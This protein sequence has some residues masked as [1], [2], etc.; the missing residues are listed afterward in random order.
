MNPGI[1]YSLA[2][3]ALFASGVPLSKFLLKTADPVLFAGLCYFASG[4]GLFL[5][6]RLRRSSGEAPLARQDWPWMLGSIL[7]G[8]I[9]APILLMKGIA[10]SPQ[11]SRAAILFTSEIIFTTL[12]AGALFKEYISGRVWFAALL[13]AGGAAALSGDSAMPHGFDR[14]LV[15]IVVACFIWGFD[16]NFTTKLSGKDPATI[17]M[18]KGLVAGTFNVLLALHGGA[19]LPSPQVFAG[20]MVTGF[21]AYGLSLIVFVKGMRALGA[22][23]STALFGT[24]PFV[25]AL[26]SVIFLHD[27]LSWGFFGAFALNAAAAFVLFTERHAH[28]HEHGQL[29]HDH[30][31]THDA[32]HQHKHEPGT[33]LTEPHS[34][35]HIHGQLVHN[36]EHM[37]DE[38]HRHKH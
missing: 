6:S 8:G 31:H 23:R 27:P 36:H 13:V 1:W 3:S 17:G 12:I 7:C 26:L 16:N 2:G 20:A 34:H 28:K 32:H 14:G 19:K 4:A 25:A 18:W 30:L 5:L 15:L 10:L 22:A 11:A 29:V 9:I 24:N 21:V 35:E 37:P 33:D 38:H